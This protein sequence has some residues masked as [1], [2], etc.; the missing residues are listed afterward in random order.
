MLNKFFGA[1]M[2]KALITAISI[3]G[4]IL[5]LNS[6]SDEPVTP[7]P[8][9]TLTANKYFPATV[10]SWWQY[11][12]HE[13]NEDGTIDESKTYDYKMVSSKIEVKA[14]KTSAVFQIQDLTGTKIEDN[15]FYYTTKEQIWSYTKLIPDM[16]FTLPIALTE[17][18]FKVADENGTEWVLYTEY[19]KNVNIEFNSVTI[20]LDDT[21]SITMKNEGMQTVNYGANNE[22]SV[23]AIVYKKTV[24]YGGNAKVAGAIPVQIPFAVETYYYYA[25]GIGLVK[26]EVKPWS[27]GAMGMNIYNYGNEQIL[28]EYEVK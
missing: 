1:L 11:Q 17:N 20:V 27:V 9:P 8:T 6:C 21:L 15:Q 19:L 3:M 12:N 4:L 7:T 16:D 13:F 5:F 26:S 18:W 2:K 10:G 25:D 22:K 24:A 14:G 28:V 23:E